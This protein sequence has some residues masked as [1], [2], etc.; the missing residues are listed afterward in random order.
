[1]R[2]EK[3]ESLKIPKSENQSE[4]AKKN[5][6]ALDLS[7]PIWCLRLFI[8][9][10]LLKTKNK[11]VINEH[12]EEILNLITTNRILM[13]KKLVRKF[14]ILTNFDVKNNVIKF[15][16]NMVGTTIFEFSFKY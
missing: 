14:N 7:L 3:S 12:G 5:E 10:T 6:L 13:W 1:M 8:V 15:R 2:I 9:H 4:G 11:Q 16:K